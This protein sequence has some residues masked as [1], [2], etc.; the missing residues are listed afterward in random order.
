MDPTHVSLRDGWDFG[1]RGRGVSFLR[2]GSNTGSHIFRRTR[3]SRTLCAKGTLFNLDLLVNGSV[4]GLVGSFFRDCMFFQGEGMARVG[5][6]FF[7]VG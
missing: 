4:Q 1:T 5:A 2:F 6:S 7:V 3:R